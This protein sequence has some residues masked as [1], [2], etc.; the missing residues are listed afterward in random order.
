MPLLWVYFSFIEFILLIADLQG[1]ITLFFLVTN[2][3]VLAP[4]MDKSDFIYCIWN[5][6][7]C[8]C[9]CLLGSRAS[10]L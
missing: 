2:L 1:A 5:V 10:G 6:L 9:P 8:R 7:M 3:I 4:L